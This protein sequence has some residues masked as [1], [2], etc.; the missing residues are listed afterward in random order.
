MEKDGTYYCE[1]CNQAIHEVNLIKKE[2]NSVEHH[3]HN[4]CLD[5]EEKKYNEHMEQVQKYYDQMGEAQRKMLA[6]GIK[7]WLFCMFVSFGFGV[8]IGILWCK[9]FMV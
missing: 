6:K 8:F 2:V 4:V 7:I 1:I 3:F 5:K 9:A